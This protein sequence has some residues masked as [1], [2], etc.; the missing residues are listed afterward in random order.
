MLCEPRVG[1]VQQASFSGFETLPA[2]QL[3]RLEHVLQ[4]CQRQLAEALQAAA[5]AADT[6]VGTCRHDAH[7]G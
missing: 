4:A 7:G 5:A 6:G 2:A 3:R 1:V